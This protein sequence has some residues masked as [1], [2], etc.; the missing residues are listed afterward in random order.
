MV[1]I[2][3]VASVCSAMAQKGEKAVGLQ[4][5]YGTQIES[6][7]IGAKFQYGITNAIRLEPSFN[8][9]FGKS[10]GNMF[11]FNV[12]AHYLF[13]VAPKVKV[14]PLVGIGYA[15]I[16]GGGG[17]DIS[18]DGGESWEDYG[19][20]YDEDWSDEGSSSSSRSGNFT[21]NLGAGAE[22][23]LTDRLSINAEVKYQIISN[24][25]QVVVGIGAAYKF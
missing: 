14:Y 17:I 5:N 25:N 23:Q 4:L 12:N 7:G 22:Y 1:A 24:F 16:S 18:Y 3:L 19:Y 9:F 6:M 21:V 10:G 2:V 11:D 20:E 8:Y 15:S 13:D